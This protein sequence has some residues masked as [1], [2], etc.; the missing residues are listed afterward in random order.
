MSHF[1][2]NGRSYNFY[3]VGGARSERK[4]W[5][6]VSDDT[7]VL[8]FTFDASGFKQPLREDETQNM[9]LESF[10]LWESIVKS[11]TFA[12][13][14]IMVLF[15]KVDRLAT[16]LAQSPPLSHFNGLFLEKTKTVDDILRGL[17]NHLISKLHNNDGQERPPRW[18]TFWHTSIESSSTEMAEVM[19]SALEHIE[20]MKPITTDE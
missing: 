18:M 12:K 9:V 4:K 6:I 1:E 13:S 7:D 15:T 20:K 2:A 5:S 16:L 3:D 19:L 10:L 17:A 8:V 11:H 14:H